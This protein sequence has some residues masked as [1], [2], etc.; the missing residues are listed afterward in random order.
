MRC[1]IPREVSP[2]TVH[3]DKKHDR[4]ETP[5]HY[6]AGT[7]SDTNALMAEVHHDGG[8][9]TLMTAGGYSLVVVLDNL[10]QRN[11]IE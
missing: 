10:A 8:A 2:V 7:A 6:C 11:L 1:S 3:E 4:C 9:T 5:R